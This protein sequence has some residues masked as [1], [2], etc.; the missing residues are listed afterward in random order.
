V[1]EA[2]KRL[3][4]IGTA[5]V[6]ARSIQDV[7]EAIENERPQAVAV[8]LDLRRY[9]ALTEGAREDI[10]IISA[11]KSGQG[12]LLLFQ[13]LLS[14]FQR[15]M[16]EEYGIKPGA[17]MLAAIEKA[18]EIGADILLIDRDIAITMRRFWSSLSFIEKLRFIYE[19][20]KGIFGGED[21]EVDEMLEDDI[22]K[23]MM[24]E[25][26]SIS[27][28]AAEVLIDERDAY[29]AGN[30]LKALTRYDSIVA[31]VGAGHKEGIEGFLR[32]PAKI[33]P[34][35]E[36]EKVE[37]KRFSVFKLISYTI[38]A[39]VVLIF[40]AVISTMN[41]EIILKAFAIWFLANGILS[42]AGAAIAGAHP[43]SILA[44][45]LSA[46]MT[47]LNPAIAAG[48]VSGLVEAWIRKPGAKDI[49]ELSKAQSIRDL[50]RNRL[51]KILLVAALTNIGSMAGTII[52]G[53]YAWKVTGID[54]AATIKERVLE[55]LT[56][57][58][59]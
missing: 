19:L 8:E 30:L 3:V 58:R 7:K 34:V 40:A 20:M 25:F 53:Y 11:I 46:W 22:L 12:Y 28:K 42:A 31:V 14:Y 26:R 37:T 15:K 4:I 50:L 35:S 1:N 17:E 5:H 6:S 2:N 51:F 48:W 52:G 9:K 57:F 23:V 44:A 13:I 24:K 10:D 54:V 27:P 45:F 29:M 32:D 49:E 21:V 16:G 36:L 38:L 59:P 56:F 47:S 41:T 55:V 39:V 43:F 33:P 18:R